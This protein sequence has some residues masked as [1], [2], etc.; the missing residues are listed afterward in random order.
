MMKP[1]ADIWN[2]TTASTFR[3]YVAQLKELGVQYI[4]VGF[5]NES[6]SNMRTLIPQIINSGFQVLGLLMEKSYAPNNPTGW[7]DWVTSVVNEFKQY[8]HVWECWNE[9]NQTNIFFNG[10]TKEQYVDFLKECYTHAKAADPT[11]QVWGGSIAFTHNAAISWLTAIYENG[12]KDYMDGVAWHPYCNPY[13]PEAGYPNSHPNNP[14]EWLTR[15]KAEM[16]RWGDTRNIWI[17]ELGWQSN[18]PTDPNLPTI[19]QQLQADYTVEALK[20]AYDWGWVEGYILYSYRDS[21]TMT[22]KMGLVTSSLTPKLSF[23]AVKDFIWNYIPPPTPILFDLPTI[24]G[25]ALGITDA[26]LI[27]YGLAHLAGLI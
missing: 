16:E 23:Y 19:N 8:V 5:A 3:S 10:G 21:S 6:L 15:V 4:R 7:G 12:G 20:M 14:Y 27:I 25:I 2:M 24:G 1:G 26:A 22:D 11:C 17:T 13:R 9:P 18:A